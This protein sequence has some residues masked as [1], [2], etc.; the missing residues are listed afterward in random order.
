MGNIARTPEDVLLGEAAA[1]DFQ[2]MLSIASVIANRAAFLNTTPEDVVAN[3][4]EF[5]AYGRALPAGVEKYRD[6]AREAFDYVA[7]AGPVNRATFYATPDA[8][9]NLPNGLSLVDRTAGHQYYE[10][11]YGRPINT[12]TGYKTPQAPEMVYQTPDLGPVPDYRPDY[13]M[14]AAAAQPGGYGLAGIS[15]SFVSQIESSGAKGT[16]SSFDRSGLSPSAS[17]MVNSMVGLGLGDLGVNSGYRSPAANAAADGANRSQHMG[18]NAID[19]ATRSL[20]APEKERILDAALSGGAKGIGL[21]GPGSM[22][23]DTRQTP[24][25]WGPQGFSNPGRTMPEKIANMPEWSQPNLTAL[26]DAQGYNYLPSGSNFNV[27]TPSARP[28]APKS[29]SPSLDLMA[30]DPAKS[31]ELNYATPQAPVAAYAEPE[32]LSTPFDSVM[33]VPSAPTAPSVSA[34]TDA[35]VSAPNAGKAP[36]APIDKV[37]EIATKTP[38]APDLAS[39]YASYGAG[40]QLKEQAANLALDVAQAKGIAPN[41]MPTAPA[42]ATQPNAPKAPSITDVQPK[43]PDLP[44]ARNVSNTPQVKTV[45]S[46]YSK[47][48]E[49]NKSNAMR[50]SLALA[51]LQKQD[52]IVNG[53]VGALGSVVGGMFLGPIGGI[54]GAQFAPKLLAPI[55]NQAPKFYPTAPVNPNYSGGGSGYDSLSDYG[56]ETYNSSGQFRDAVDAVDS[57]KSQG[58]L[59]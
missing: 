32:K 29:V 26:V 1:G 12:S 55:T 58:G 57:G 35:K 27:P 47:A 33:N 16:L 9:S 2:D 44:A 31:P 46:Q 39:Q 30:F 24:A 53:I 28:E 19:L 59:W 23:V 7:K 3:K 49:T 22:H 17:A 13:E 15:P 34:Y 43:A 11:P 54:L 41:F 25:F 10:D 56:R 20:S 45:D 51:G 37:T 18:G 42:I 21:Y 8:A 14:E 5:N 40:R 38:E 52:Q 4:R 6:L 36:S 48:A 50:D